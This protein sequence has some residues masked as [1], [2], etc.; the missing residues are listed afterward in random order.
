MITLVVNGKKRELKAPTDL[1]A[2][3]K[4]NNVNT[5]FVA[6]AHNGMILSKEEYPKVILKDGDT[7]EIIRPVGGG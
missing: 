1:V 4:E 2:F 7:L 6:V 3:L 5:T